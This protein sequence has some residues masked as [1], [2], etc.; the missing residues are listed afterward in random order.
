MRTKQTGRKAEASELPSK[1]KMTKREVRDLV[2]MDDIKYTICEILD[3]ID[4]GCSF[5]TYGSY[6]EAPLPDLHL[7]GYGPL[8]LPLT[9]RDVDTICKERTEG[10]NGTGSMQLQTTEEMA[11]TD[12]TDVA[13]QV[14]KPVHGL[15]GPQSQWETKSGNILMRNPAWNGFVQKIAGKAARDLG[16]KKDA[17]AVDAKL[18]KARFWKAGARI[19]P[20]KE[21]VI[22]T[23]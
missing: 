22:Q 20:H 12:C 19:P 1:K 8:P 4:S 13:A 17:G 14:M 2:L 3:G 21:W 10:D 7:R 6:S 18:V 9:K 16:T 11:K 23:P 15:S 5:A